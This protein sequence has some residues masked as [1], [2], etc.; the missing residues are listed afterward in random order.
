MIPYEDLERALARWKSRARDG[1]TPEPTGEVEEL[2]TLPH[3]NNGLPPPREQTG[4]ID[5]G[6][7]VVES[8]DVHRS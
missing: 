1:A 5:I 2:G 7:E 8:I 6:D 3:N 4:E